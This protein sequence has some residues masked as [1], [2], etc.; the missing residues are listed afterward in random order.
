[1][2][3]SAN[4]FTTAETGKKNASVQ[5]IERD[6]DG[7]ITDVHFTIDATTYQKNDKKGTAKVTIRGKGDF[8]GEKVVTFSIT[9]RN[10]VTEGNWWKKLMDKFFA[11]L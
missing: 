5:L 2:T 6:K 10:V 1:M 4:D 9:Q 8:G 11:W 7:K 3:I